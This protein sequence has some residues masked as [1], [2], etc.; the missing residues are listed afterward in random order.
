MSAA[1]YDII[2]NKGSVF[3]MSIQLVDDVT[4]NPIDL[5][6]AVGT[7]KIATKDFTTVLCVVDDVHAD[8]GS[9][10][11][12]EPLVGKALILI[13]SDATAALPNPPKND[14]PF[15]EGQYYVYQLDITQDG[16]TKRYMQGFVTIIRGI[17]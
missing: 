4:A 16:K 7:L 3:E 11:I 14:D 5:T 2:I 10:S 8:N 15:Y 17:T 13:S 9:I 12:L 6:G 1:R